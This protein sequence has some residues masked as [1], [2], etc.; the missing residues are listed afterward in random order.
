MTLSH[1]AGGSPAISPNSTVILG[2]RVHGG[3]DGIGEPDAV[4]G[5]RAARRE[6]VGVGGAHDQR[7]A[8]PHFFVQQADGVV[9]VVVGAEGVGADELGK[10]AGQ[11]GLGE[12]VRP[13][14][15]QDDGRAGFRRLP[16]GFEPA[17]P[18]PIM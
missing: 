10:A 17:R 18:A 7:A 12:L 11:V 16:G 3:G 9:L 1:S 5:Q 4:H 8:A 2:W 15:V 6:L 13:H 14:F